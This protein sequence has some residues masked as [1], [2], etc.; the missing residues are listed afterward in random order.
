MDDEQTDNTA[1]L[2]DLPDV[3]F[4]ELSDGR[5][6]GVVS[7]ESQA[8]RVYASSI[9]AEDHGLSC[10]SNDDLRCGGLGEDQACR[11]IEALLAQ[12]VRE[13]GAGRVARYLKIEVVEGVALRDG[14][15]PTSAP[16]HAPEIFQSFLRHM[17]Y[18]Q[19]PV[20]GTPTV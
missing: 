7:S 14:L 18:L 4:L 1:D 5:L 15:H 19:M 3:P 2:P 8:E 13:F 10:C 16:S 20:T 11:H 17:A 9:S 12:A 6:Q